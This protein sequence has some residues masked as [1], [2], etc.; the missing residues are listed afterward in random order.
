V[1]NKPYLT[2]FAF[3]KTGLVVPHYPGQRVLDV[4]PDGLEADAI[5]AGSLWN[6]GQEPVSEL[7]DWWLNLPVGWETRDSSSEPADA[8]V[9]TSGAATNDLTDGDGGRVIEVKGL[10]I[11]VGTDALGVA[12]DRP[13]A[14]TAEEVLIEHPSG[15]ASIAIDSDGNI[16][17][18]TD[19]TITFAAKKVVFEV[20]ENVEVNP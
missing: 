16:T 9:P 18:T 20:D 10:R 13:E 12:G 3:G 8:S 4:H 1:E 17:I 14:A 15:G 2:P 5:V 7:G 11:S 19:E 6:D